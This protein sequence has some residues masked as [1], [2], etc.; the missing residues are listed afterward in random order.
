V[1]QQVDNILRY[2]NASQASID[3]S[4]YDDEIILFINDNGMGCDL[5]ERKNGAG[6]K[7]IISRANLYHGSVTTLSSPGEGYILQVIFRL[8]DSHY[9]KSILYY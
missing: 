1:Q 8:D 6:I 3:I 9:D 7:S 4:K 5:I 2:A